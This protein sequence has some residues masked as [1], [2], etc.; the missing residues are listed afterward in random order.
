MFLNI[1]IDLQH[2]IFDR[3]EIQDRVKLNI[4]LG[5]DHQIISTHKTSAELNKQLKYLTYNIKRW[6]IKLYKDLVFPWRMFILNHLN[7][8]TVQ[9]IGVHLQRDPLCYNSLVD[10]IRNNTVSTT[11]EYKIPVFSSCYTSVYDCMMAVVGWA[12]SHTFDKLMRTPRFENLM[13]FLT[14]VWMDGSTFLGYVVLYAKRD[15]AAHIM[16]N[17]RNADFV[18]KWFD[19]INNSLVY[20]LDT[21]AY[22]LEPAKIA[23]EIIGISNELKLKLLDSAIKYMKFDTVD[24]LVNEQ[25]VPFTV[26]DRFDTIN[27][28]LKCL[29]YYMERYE[30][31]DYANLPRKWKKFIG[32]HEDEPTIKSLGMQRDPLSNESFFDDIENNMISKTNEYKIAS[33][34]LGVIPSCSFMYMIATLTPYTFE[35][36]LHTPRFENLMNIV[37]QDMDGSTFLGYV[38]LAENRDLATHIMQNHRNA[39]FV[40]KSFDKVCD[41]IYYNAKPMSLERAKIACEIIGISHEQKIKLLDLAIKDMRLNIIDYIINEQHVRHI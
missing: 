11:T 37:H 10:D 23:C 16:L 12:S 35:V 27:K 25:K 3:L 38:V 7:E 15:L 36:L 40:V 1:P 17:Y 9:H 20:R 21:S 2:D 30:I 39:D 32:R 14:T 34:D 18:V 33:S 29:M 31:T 19:Q 6:D 41:S 26:F 22:Q 13:N 28:Q 4:A 24:Y 5:P 8:P